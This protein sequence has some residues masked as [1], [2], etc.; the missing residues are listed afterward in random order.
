[1]THL[2]KLSERGNG[3]ALHRT[4]QQ[5]ISTLADIR[6]L[7]AHLQIEV[8]KANREGRELFVELWT[9]YPEPKRTT[10]LPSG[11]SSGM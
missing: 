8:Q 1:M 4:Y 10:L 3:D 5:P 2:I 7:V 9:D 11:P 6:E